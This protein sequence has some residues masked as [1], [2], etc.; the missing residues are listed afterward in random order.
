MHPSQGCDTMFCSSHCPRAQNIVSLDTMFCSPLCPRA[1]NIV[2]FHKP[3]KL[4]DSD[5]GAHCLPF[6]RRPPIPP[7]PF[8][9]RDRPPRQ[10]PTDV[11]PL[12]PTPPPLPTPRTHPGPTRTY[13]TS[14]ASCSRKKRKKWEGGENFPRKLSRTIT[15]H[16]TGT[17]LIRASFCA[18]VDVVNRPTSWFERPAQTDRP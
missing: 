6:N 2:S 14:P 3:L 13:K 11:G 4:L 15:G 7:S 18:R 16:G 9:P 8:P 17:A 5:E 1:Q 10:A 12:P